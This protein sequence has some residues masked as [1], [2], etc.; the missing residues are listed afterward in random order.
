M[1][2]NIKISDNEFNV[3]SFKFSARLTIT[4]MKLLQCSLLQDSALNYA[5]FIRQMLACLACHGH[6]QK[7]KP[8]MYAIVNLTQEKET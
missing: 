7:I 5:F 8:Q 3:G 1:S 2:G 6:T 4:F